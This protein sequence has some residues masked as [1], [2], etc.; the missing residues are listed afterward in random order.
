MLSIT[1]HRPLR[2]LLY[3]AA[4]LPLAL[5]GAN[6][7]AQS[8][9][10]AQQ[11]PI[12][13]LTQPAQ[14]P[15]SNNAI[16]LTD[17]VS[18]PHL[19]DVTYFT[20]TGHTLRG[21]FLE[22][23]QHNGGLAQFGYP[24]TE[25]FTEPMGPNNGPIMVQYFERNRFE[26]HPENAGT[27]YEVLLG[28]LGRE[29]HAQDAAAQTLPA[30]AVYFQETGHNLSGTFK[31][32]WEAHGGLA[33]HGYPITEQFVETN[34]TNHKEY[35]VQYFERSRFELHPENAGS[36]Y[37]VLLGQLGVQLSQKKGYPYGWYPLISHSADMSWISG[38]L[39][40]YEQPGCANS[41]CGCSVFEYGNNRERVQL[42]TLAGGSY[43]FSRSI[44]GAQVP[45]V[46]FGRGAQA[47]EHISICPAQ[48]NV[49]GYFARRIQTNPVR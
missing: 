32:Y 28:T 15:Q 4:L 33:V 23:W 49:Q 21:S 43:P 34:P 41:A 22:Y 7:S 3:A 47:Q 25:E 35:S 24:L 48:P 17:P 37:E 16:L 40:L 46:A 27:Q 19:A 45:L 36:A 20:T 18:D 31:A 9:T 29:F 2:A 44:S 8:N 10:P 26:H 38:Y 13:Q 11:S 1:G 12:A 42:N 14:T 6:S 39:A 30:P 5:G